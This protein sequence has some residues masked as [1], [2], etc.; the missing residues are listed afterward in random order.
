MAPSWDQLTAEELVAK[1][2]APIKKEYWL[3]D[4]GMAPVQQSK[5]LDKKKSGRQEKRVCWHAFMH[6]DEAAYG[7]LDWQAELQR[8]HG[9][10]KGLN[11]N[12]AQVEQER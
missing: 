8:C 1:C 7:R 5:V 6:V 4:E 2:I 10:L 3:E 12:S 11:S 9:K